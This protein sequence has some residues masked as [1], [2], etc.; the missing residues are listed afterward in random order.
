MSWTGLFYRIAT[1]RWWAIAGVIA[2]G[3]VM[4]MLKRGHG[5]SPLHGF[6]DAAV[7]ALVLWAG[8]LMTWRAA[9]ER[10]ARRDL[11][12][13]RAEWKATCALMAARLQA[14][15]VS[16]R[17]DDT[18]ET[19]ELKATLSRRH[20]ALVA[21]AA[22]LDQGTEPALEP[23][24]LAQST[25]IE[26]QDAQGGDLVARLAGLQRDALVEAERRQWLTTGRFTALEGN[27]CQ[28]TALPSPDK[29]WT[30]GYTRLSSVVV[31]LT[32]WILPLA[33]PPRL[34]GLALAATVALL[35]IA[36]DALSD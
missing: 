34:A 4:L 26:R 33:A 29:S 6:W 7:I 27:L 22:A 32:A 28:V 5:A 18:P 3:L 35:L 36:F 23:A 13:R 30:S 24:V 17:D 25:A 1:R 9:D 31:T 11:T 21:A 20:S 15:I 12:Q 14:L 19:D 2:T 16:T 10:H 8:V